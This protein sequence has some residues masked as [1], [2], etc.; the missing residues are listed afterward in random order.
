MNH[1][2][3][4]NSLFEVA[5]AKAQPKECIPP[6]LNQRQFTG[7]TIV[8]GAGKASANMAQ[9]VEK[10][11]SGNIEGLVV[12]R[13]NHSVPCMNIDVLEAGHPVPDRNG[14]IAASRMLKIA[15]GL[16]ENDK[17]ICLISGGGS[18]LLSLPAPGIS[19]EHKQKITSGLL[20]SGATIHEINSVRKHLSA[21]KGGRLGIACYPAKL[22]TLAISDVSGDDLG[23]I[24]S[25]PT[26]ED[27]TTFDDAINVLK[28]YKITKPIQVLDYLENATDETPKPGDRKLKNVENFLIATAKQSL[29]AAAKFA[30]EAGV[31][32]LILS[33]RV[34]GEAR[35]VAKEQVLQALEIQKQVK[36]DSKSVVLLSGGET[37]VTVRGGG[38]GGPNT[39]YML[40]M[41]VE[42]R[43]QDGI[44]AISC[45]T[46]GIDGTGNNAGAFIGPESFKLSDSLG[47]N[48]E[49]FLANNDSYNFFS[50]IG[51]LVSPGPTLTNVN[52]FRAILIMPSGQNQ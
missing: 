49:K 17:V 32:P 2:K 28:K 16:K 44:W 7:R 30:E 14:M 26:V 37:C 35:E 12:T 9:V 5:V 29:D 23:V 34:E 4:L 31:I 1:R 40:S 3:F 51:A 10:H 21:I 41:L 43:G 18:S 19:L 39:E 25:G 8:F 45:D 6:F 42:L 46:D 22:I 36:S 47:L 13:Y 52:D 33:D 11:F 24:A 38:L 27:L 15:S 48:P 20:K 50:K